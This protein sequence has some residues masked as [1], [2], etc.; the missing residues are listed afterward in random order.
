LDEI[1]VNLPR[2][3]EAER[4]ELEIRPRDIMGCFAKQIG[5]IMSNGTF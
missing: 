1:N 3:T 4:K 2:F 5:I